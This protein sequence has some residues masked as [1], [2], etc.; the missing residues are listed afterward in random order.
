MRAAHLVGLAARSAAA[1]V[2]LRNV[3]RAADRQAPVTATTSP[4]PTISG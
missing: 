4:V 1:A 3:V 2:V